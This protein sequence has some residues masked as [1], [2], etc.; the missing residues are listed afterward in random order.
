M[1]PIFYI[2]NRSIRLSGITQ[3]YWHHI[4]L[5]LFTLTLDRELLNCLFSSVRSVVLRMF[6][7]GNKPACFT[8]GF[9]CALHTFGRNLKWNPHI[10]CLISEGGIGNSELWRPFKY[11]NYKL[12]RQFF[13][14]ALLNELHEEIGDPIQKSKSIRLP[15]SEE[16]FLC[17]CQTSPLQSL[18]VTR[19]IGRY[20]RRPVIATS[21]IDKYDG[22]LVTFHYNRHEDDK[23]IYETIPVLDFM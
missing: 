12:L 9:I 17:L 5:L 3:I 6:R 1:F 22:E 20:F 15:E 7:K 2:N 21:R 13:Q 11:F 4:L 14:T 18:I 8:P 23:L 16:W 10:H 19:Y